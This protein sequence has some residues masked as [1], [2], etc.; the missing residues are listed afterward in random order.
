MGAIEILLIETMVVLFSALF[1]FVLCFVI[2]KRFSVAVW[3]YVAAYIPRIPVVIVAATGGTNLLLFAWLNH[4]LGILVYPVILA[5]ID[6]LLLEI[7]F[8]RV[9]KPIAFML[10]KDLQTV[11]KIESFLNRLQEYHAIPKPVRV[12]WVYEAGVIAGIVNLIFLAG[13]G[14]L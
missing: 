1:S 6:V 7:A 12:K 3:G 8:I 5:I 10:P 2:Y 4:T 9:V 13:F 11:I 14:L